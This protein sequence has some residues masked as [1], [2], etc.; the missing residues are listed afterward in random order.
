[1]LSLPAKL[2]VEN[3]TARDCKQDCRHHA[4]LSF[5][6]RGRAAFPLQ[7]KLLL[8]K[9]ELVENTAGAWMSPL[10][11][12]HSKGDMVAEKY[13]I[14]G[15]LGQ[16]GVATTYEAETPDRERVAL[17]A[18]SLRSLKGWKELELFEREARVLKSLQH[19]GIPKYI[20]YFEVDSTTDRA[21]YIAQMVAKGSSLADLVQ[22]GWHATE[23]EVKRIA[24]EVLEILQYLGSLRPPVIHRDVKPENIIL[25]EATGKVKLVD[26]GAVQDA[27]AFTLVGSTV[28]GTYGY[29]APEQFQNRATLQSDLYGLGCTILFLVSGRHPSSFPQ[30]RLRIE[31]QDA[32]VVD[33]NLKRVLERLLEPAP[34]D[35]F[36]AAEEVIKALKDDNNA[37]RKVDDYV[38]ESIST[39]RA[40]KP[41]GTKVVLK[42]TASS[43][44]VSIPPMGFTTDALGS[45]SF[46]LAWNAFLMFWTSSAITGGAPLFFTIFSLPFWFV[47]VRLAKES[48]S[49]FAVSVDMHFTLSKFFI[50]WRVGQFFRKKIEGDIRDIGSVK[51][52]VEGARNGRVIT[53]C[54]ILEGTKEHKFGS[55]LEIVELDWL[56][57]ELGEFLELGKP[58]LGKVSRSTSVKGFRR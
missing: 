35:R 22:N 37:I 27:A 15:I 25:D 52:A 20:D 8:V 53:S 23:E 18:M 44:T 24:I 4:P 7:Q 45:G 42:R 9:A 14:I 28:V 50:Q 47:G 10:S 6:R 12:V 39:Q 58:N 36:Q 56:V 32:L 26:F 57:E 46:A 13:Q 33:Y 51:I 11:V 29:M 1:M 17:K 19:P 40:R 21:F 43:L 5:F 38:N 3:R 16:G 34:E 2:Q 49:S 30:K 55:G 31:F 41:S 48:L 54:Q